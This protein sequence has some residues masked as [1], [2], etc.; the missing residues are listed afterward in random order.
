M[1]EPGEVGERQRETDVCAFEPVGGVEQDRRAAPRQQVDEH[2]PVRRPEGA[3]VEARQRAAGRTC[4]R[5]HRAARPA[6]AGP[7]AQ[8]AIA[9]ASA[10][11]VAPWPRRERRDVIGEPPATGPAGD[12]HSGA[13][14]GIAAMPDQQLD[15]RVG[16][17]AEA[18][19][20]HGEHPL[21]LEHRPLGDDRR[22]HVAT[23][24]GAAPRSSVDSGGCSGADAAGPGHERGPSGSSDGTDRGE[25]ARRV[26]GPDGVGDEVGDRAG[27]GI[28]RRSRRSVPRSAAVTSSTPVPLS[29]RDRR[30]PG[31]CG[32]HE[33]RVGPRT[34]VER[35]V[36]EVHRERLHALRGPFDR[37][38]PPAGPAEAASSVA[39][40]RLS[41]TSGSEP[42]ASVSTHRPSSTAGVARTVAG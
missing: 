38:C 37:E 4:G 15:G 27:G 2:R 22:R 14:N 39:S 1:A 36:V 17:H 12:G 9:T 42:V 7:A 40:A 33:G 10:D 25:H 34:D 30:R 8:A 6:R 35:A 28:G 41:P 23:A 18:L 24:D 21:V 32:P 26:V 13:A 29:I 31:S 19:L 11:T 20:D 3:G 5:R 16:R